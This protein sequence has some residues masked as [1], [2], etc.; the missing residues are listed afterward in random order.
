[1]RRDQLEAAHQATQRF[2]D[3]RLRV[4]KPFQSLILSP[5]FESFRK[6]LKKAIKSQL[7]AVA[8]A[9]E[10]KA[11]LATPDIIQGFIDTHLPPLSSYFDKQEVF[12]YLQFCFIEGVRAQYGR[13]GLKTTASKVSFSYENDLAFELTNQNL[14]DALMQDADF[15]L[16][17]STIDATTRQQLIDMIQEAKLENATIDEI[18]STI[19]DA[20]PDISENRAFVIS[21]T[22][23]ARAMG[24]G[25]YQAMVQ[26]GVQKKK[27]IPAGGHACE[28]CL[29]NADDGEI[30]V[31]ED[32]SSGDSYEP[33][34]PNC[35]CYTQAGEIDLDSI[36]IWDGS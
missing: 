2:I 12:D 22:E 31:D 19:T 30:P 1:M 7:K 29:G 23:T 5:Q 20:M 4:N 32:F 9:M 24:Q 11:V 8:D 15:L 3:K 33:A 28:I 16:N 27:W 34:H 10:G 25:N 36:D 26:N 17:Q 14:I 13:L 6:D 21:R 35:E 18:A